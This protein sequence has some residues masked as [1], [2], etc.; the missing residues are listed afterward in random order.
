MFYIFDL[1]VALNNT[2]CDYKIN[3]YRNISVYGTSR[4]S[5]KS[6]VCLA[7]VSNL[8]SSRHGAKL[9]HQTTCAGSYTKT[10]YIRLVDKTSIHK[11]WVFSLLFK[12]AFKWSYLLANLNLHEVNEER[13]RLI[14]WQGSFTC[15]SCL[16]HCRG[17]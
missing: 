2:S 5:L 3:N 10:I 4:T 12:V 14:T 1:L 6:L 7:R 8:G 17:F 13:H 15:L 16:S 11:S 9:Y